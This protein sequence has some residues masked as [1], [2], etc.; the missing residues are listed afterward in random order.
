[1]IRLVPDQAG[2]VQRSALVT[3]TFDGMPVQGHLGETLVAALTRAGHLGLRH[4][5]SDGALRGAFCCMGLCQE[6][7]V[8]VRGQIVEA[9]GTEVSPDLIVERV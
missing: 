2:Q 1:M 7:A 8:V 9:C 5:P 6:C 4:A 3:F